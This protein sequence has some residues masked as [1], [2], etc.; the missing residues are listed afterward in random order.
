MGK[1]K[2]EKVKEETKPTP[3]K[4]KKVELPGRTALRGRGVGTAS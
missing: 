3:Q 2:V 1:K 4:K